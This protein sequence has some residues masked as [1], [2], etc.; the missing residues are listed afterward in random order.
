MKKSWL[1]E[2]IGEIFWIRATGW[3]DPD[4]VQMTFTKLILPFWNQQALLF[5]TY[6]GAEDLILFKRPSP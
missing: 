3:G 5:C 6:E 2:Q 1:L 4:P